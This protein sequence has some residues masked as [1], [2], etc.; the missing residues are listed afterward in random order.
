MCRGIASP[1]KIP[2]PSKVCAPIDFAAMEFPSYALL[3]PNFEL[4]ALHP[5]TIDSIYR[6]DTWTIDLGRFN[7]LFAQVG[8]DLLIKAR[9]MKITRP[10]VYAS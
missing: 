6:I 1:F 10:L 7:G 3:R 8:L 2:R 5:E 9:D 4:S